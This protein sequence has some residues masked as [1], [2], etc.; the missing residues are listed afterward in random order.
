[1]HTTI[2]A[3]EAERFIIT[4]FVTEIPGAL[5]V[6]GSISLLTAVSG[7]V[8]WLF[9]R[10]QLPRLRPVLSLPLATGGVGALALVLWPLVGAIHPATAVLLLLAPALALAVATSC[11]GWIGLRWRVFN[12]AKCGNCEQRLLADQTKCPEC[13]ADRRQDWGRRQNM[14]LTLAW[15]AL[16]S[17]AVSMVAVAA[18]LVVPLEWRARIDANLESSSGDSAVNVMADGRVHVAANA[19]PFIDFADNF[20]LREAWNAWASPVSPNGGRVAGVQVLP[21]QGVAADEAWFA[22][23]PER[24]A[25]FSASEASRTVAWARDAVERPKGLRSAPSDALASITTSCELLFPSPWVLVFVAVC[26]PLAALLA[27]LVSRGRRTSRA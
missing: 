5:L 22:A 12:D 15:L 24:T 1:M 11:G 4:R 27:W 3:T 25:A 9:L 8:L 23:L 20:P 2:L 26:G 21:S 10:R 18:L 16:A 6:F 13:G 17:A 7:G 19:M 14:V